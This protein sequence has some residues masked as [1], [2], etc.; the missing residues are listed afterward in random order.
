MKIYLLLLLVN[1][2]FYSG[3]VAAQNHDYN[4]P[5]GYDNGGPIT[6]EFGG[7]TILFN[8]IP[9]QVQKQNRILNF[10]TFCGACSDSS[11]SL[12]FYTN[13]IAI[14]NFMNELMENGDT[15]NPGDVWAGSVQSGYPNEQ[16]GFALPFPGHPNLYY[17]FYTGFFYDPIEQ[18]AKATPFYY[19]LIDMSANNGEGKV[20][21]KN[22]ILMEGKLG[23]PAACKHGNGRDWWITN[24][25]LSSPE[26]YT[27]LLCP[28]GLLG[29]FI[30]SIG[31]SFPEEE[32]GSK[33]VFSPDGRL[34]VRH[35]G[36]NGPRIMDFDRCTGLFSDLYVLS[37]PPEIFSWSASFSNDSRFLFLTKPSVIWQ[38]DLQAQDWALSFDTIARYQG[39]FCPF[40]PWEAKIWTTQEGPDG[41]I[42]ASCATGGSRCMNRIEQ[43]LLPG[44]AAD[45]AFG[46]FDLPRWNDLTMCHFPNYRLGENEGSPCDTLNLQQ[47]GDGFTKSRYTPARQDRTEPY[48]ILPALPAARNETARQEKILLGDMNKVGY[49]IWL[50]RN[51]DG[52]RP[53]KN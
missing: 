40:S 24:H 44:L 38:I 53:R 30:Q 43:P 52:F 41:K 31:P 29:P 11:G 36:N 17:F 26:Q 51:R 28:Q 25:Q 2:L 49:D 21:E 32:Y 13:G 48:T 1:L 33:S 47:P 34:F 22:Q 27:Y 9:T 19:A 12:L 45:A 14:H 8:Q 5:L 46:S 10:S 39:L 37:Y 35:D 15:L 7:M 23:W 16:G 18:D 20:L 50:Q 4:W 3:H 42:Y 6:S